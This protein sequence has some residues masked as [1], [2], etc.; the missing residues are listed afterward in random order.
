MGNNRKSKSDPLWPEWSWINWRFYMLNQMYNSAKMGHAFLHYWTLWAQKHFWSNYWI[1]V[2]NKRFFLSI[3]R[4]V[5]VIMV[6]LKYVS[7]WGIWQGQRHLLE[8]CQSHELFLCG[9]KI[10]SH[11]MIFHCSCA[12]IWSLGHTSNIE[13]EAFGW[14]YIIWI[15]VVCKPYHHVWFS[16][17][18]DQL[19]AYKYHV[20][21]QF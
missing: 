21:M 4:L 6:H 15:C 14:V 3:Y 5:H 20:L 13:V 19:F 16:E 10:N 17:C 2:L 8:E 7:D 11:A 1:I 9:D 12:F 18:L